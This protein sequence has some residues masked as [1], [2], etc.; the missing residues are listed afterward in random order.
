MIPRCAH[1][2]LGAESMKIYF[3]GSVRDNIADRSIFR[4]LIL[5]LS[6]FGQVLTE[7]L[8]SSGKG[9]LDLGKTDADIFAADVDW[10]KASDVIVAD[11]TAASTGVGYQLGVAANLGKKILCLSGG[12]AAPSAMLNGN[13]KV[14]L[15]QYQT[16]EEARA[17]ITEYLSPQRI[18]VLGPPGSGKGTLS[19]LLASRFG[20]VHICSGSLL[21]PRIATE[22]D[23]LTKTLRGHVDRGELVPAM[24]MEQIVVDRIAQADCVQQ[25]C[26]LDGYPPSRADLGN[27]QRHGIAPTRVVVLTCADDVAIARQC[28][29]QT[30]PATSTIYHV[31]ARPA[32]HDVS[33]RL[34]TRATDVMPKAAQRVSL[35]NAEC[36]DVHSWFSPQVVVAVNAMGSVEEIAEIAAALL[37]PPPAPPSA[38]FAQQLK[39]EKH[40][41]RFH[42]RIDAVSHQQ[43]V[44]LFNKLSLRDT[45]AQIKIY[46]VRDLQLGR[47][48]TDP[49]FAS[50]YSRMKNF[51]SID[52][53]TTEAFATIA[54]GDAPNFET[55]SHAIELAHQHQHLS[56]MVELEENLFEF[57]TNSDGNLS[58]DYDWGQ[59][60]DLTM[61][62]ALRM[63]AQFIRSPAYELHHGFDLPKDPVRTAVLP[64]A[65]DALHRAC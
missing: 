40:S 62:D 18:F 44:V 36:N 41:Q 5:H 39:T 37:A 26:V 53:A 6:T 35:Y 16:I 64:I 29:R 38:Y 23:D 9:S 22:S 7:H 15:A 46:P 47:Q 56:P 32:P 61:P 27:L 59:P 43:V 19:Q 50:L 45:D 51:H 65:L 1:D 63:Q 31:S 55:R 60:P 25:G 33:A 20:L 14:A 2:T 10:L 17:A 8:G 28:G 11:V 4:D 58:F 34:V 57:R 42:A 52:N 54:M 30:D 13:P 21:R 3:A 49:Q 48:H 12:A 24:L